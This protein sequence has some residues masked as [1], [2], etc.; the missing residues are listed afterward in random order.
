ME[1]NPNDNLGTG[2]LGG[3]Q[4]SGLGGSSAL[5]AGTDSISVTGTSGVGGSYGSTGAGDVGS[6]DLGQSSG[7]GFGGQQSLG[8]RAGHAKDV[9]ADKFAQAKD[10]A[11]DKLGQAKEKA[12]QLKSTL[13][14]KLE[15]GASSLRQPA[16]G[17]SQFAADGSIAANGNPQLQ[18]LQETGAAAMQKSAEFLR[19]GDLKA[20]VED[21][22]RTNPGRTLLIALGL[23]YVLGKAIRGNDNRY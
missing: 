22:M 6:L 18:K 2:G 20:T 19:N 10:V 4:N 11:G 23:G 16:G 3:S 12:S 21:Q 17:A 14:D 9:A 15:A 8:D 1:R 7:S 13:A 5:G